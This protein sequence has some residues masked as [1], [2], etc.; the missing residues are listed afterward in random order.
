M[1]EHLP[2]ALA[3]ATNLTKLVLGH[4]TRLVLSAADV[5]SVLLRLPR[6]RQL[7]LDAA[8][9]PPDVLARLSSAAPQLQLI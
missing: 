8:R 6:L 5:D 4:N 2:P 3:D 9:T 1:W 7:R